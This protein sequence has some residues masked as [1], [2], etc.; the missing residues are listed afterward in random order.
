MVRVGIQEMGLRIPVILS[1][2]TRGNGSETFT[3]KSTRY[4]EDGTGVT[5][6][7]LEFVVKKYG[8]RGEF[9]ISQ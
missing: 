4:L 2:L 3:G 8:L 9:V 5:T 7:V 6:V 1:K